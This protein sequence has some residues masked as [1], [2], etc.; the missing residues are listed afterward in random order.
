[1]RIDAVVAET[2]PACGEKLGER[3]DV[4]F[5]RA[6]QV[7]R[8]RRRRGRQFHLAAGLDSDET[9]ARQGRHRAGRD[10]G[11]RSVLA[12]SGHEERQV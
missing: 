5:D 4:G 10:E 8:G 7:I 6:V 11:S 12:E 2:E 9:A 1:V 3:G